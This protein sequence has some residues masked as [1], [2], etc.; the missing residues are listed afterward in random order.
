MKRILWLLTLLLCGLT[1][2]LFLGCSDDDDDNPLKEG[3]PNSAE[4][5]FFQ[6]TVAEQP[7]Q[8]SEYALFSTIALLDSFIIPEQTQKSGYNFAT[9]EGD[10][11][12]V[13]DSVT[14]NTSGGWFVFYFEFAIYK[15][16]IYEVDT[17]EVK[18]TD[19]IKVYEGGVPVYTLVGEPDSI[20]ARQ[21][22][23]FDWWNN[24]G[25]EAT[26]SSHYNLKIAGTPPDSTVINA[27]SA[28]SLVSRFFPVDDEL[29]LC[30]LMVVST[31][32]I[33]NLVMNLDS[34]N[35]GDVC[36]SAGSIYCT[37]NLDLDCVGD[38]ALV[39]ISGTW[40]M[41]LSFDGIMETITV[42]NGEFRWSKTDVCGG[43]E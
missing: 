4:F 32:D 10:P 39:D 12:I 29:S 24:L 40:T 43:E 34:V 38:S 27:T 1:L 37:L 25:E 41:L 35:T 18:G 30:S 28:D 16:G 2:S 36:P 3:D 19:S 6:E 15:A 11:L 23:E 9:A 22:I 14:F 21:H 42:T 33:D 7:L 5:Q 20:E 26:G 8:L 17:L 31:T 13:F